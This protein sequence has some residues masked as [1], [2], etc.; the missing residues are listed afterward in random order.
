MAVVHPLRILLAIIAAAVVCAFGVLLYVGNIHGNSPVVRTVLRWAFPT[1]TLAG[2]FDF[3][4]SN[5][6]LWVS[7]LLSY[8]LWALLVYLA[9]SWLH[10]RHGRA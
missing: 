2:H 10:R 5:L 6:V 3:F 8:A 4:D 9:L 7:L 1:V